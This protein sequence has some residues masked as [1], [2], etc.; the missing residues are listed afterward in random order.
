MFKPRIYLDTSVIGGCFDN[1]F[2][3]YSN[4]LLEEFIEGKKEACDF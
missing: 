3:E 4:L 2:E 1:D